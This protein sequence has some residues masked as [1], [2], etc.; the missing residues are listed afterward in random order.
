[1]H[2]HNALYSV[3][4]QSY[5]KFLDYI[6]DENIDVRTALA[7][8]VND[9]EKIKG[10]DNYLSDCHNLLSKLSRE[11]LP[12]PKCCDIREDD[13]MR[14]GDSLEQVESY[15]KELCDYRDKIEREHK[16]TI[17][18]VNGRIQDCTNGKGANND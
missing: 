7:T 1:M 6:M 15:K 4:L 11:I 14:L 13:R 10:S 8:V 17:E 12:A 18:W 2:D 5:K 3:E 9:I 16:E